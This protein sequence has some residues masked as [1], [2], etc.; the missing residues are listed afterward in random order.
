MQS[1]VNSVQNMLI[2]IAT[3]IRM[4]YNFSMYANYNLLA[5]TMCMMAPRLSTTSVNDKHT[6]DRER[7]VFAAFV[8]AKQSASITYCIK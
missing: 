5:A 2:L 1:F 7:H 6:L 3:G 8:S 4:N